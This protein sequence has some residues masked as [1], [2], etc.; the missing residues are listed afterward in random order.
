[1]DSRNGDHVLEQTVKNTVP[2]HLLI[3]G[4]VQPS[5]AVV[6]INFTGGSGISGLPV[7]DWR[8]QGER[9]WL[10]LT[11]SSM[12]LNVGC[13]DSKLVLCDSR[14]EQKDVM[15]EE[16]KWTKLPLPAQ[17]IARLY[18]AYRKNKWYPDFDHAIKRHE[19]IETLWRDFDQ[20]QEKA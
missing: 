8:I 17:N 12:A 2:D 19:M 3:S 9:G 1:V 7:L 18:E 20:T 13:P 6:V 10:R 16:D 11:S 4:T 5:Q 15:L 14:G